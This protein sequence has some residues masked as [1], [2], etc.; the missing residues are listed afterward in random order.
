MIDCFKHLFVVVVFQFVEEVV[1]EPE[2]VTPAAS[3]NE[4]GS[5]IILNSTSEFCRNL[6]EIPTY[7]LSGNREEK[8]D[9]LMVSI[10]LNVV[11]L[12]IKLYQITQGNTFMVN[13]I[14]TLK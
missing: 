7:G 3:L 10:S 4:G 6:G 11:T 5:M 1:T 12:V 9:E 2:T 8:R 14:L 13:L